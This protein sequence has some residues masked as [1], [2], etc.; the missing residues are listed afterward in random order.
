MINRAKIR[1]RL[2]RKEN[3]AIHNEK[4]NGTLIEVIE[5]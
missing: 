3:Q 2:E 5:L 4:M 1:A